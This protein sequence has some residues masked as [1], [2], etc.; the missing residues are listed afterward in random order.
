MG[1]CECLHSWICVTCVPGALSGQG[2]R[3]I[4]GC[5]SPML[6]IGFELGSQ[7]KQYSLLTTEHL[8]NH[9]S[10]GV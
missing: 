5:E 3:A 6:V 8:S 1:I 4:R 10:S 7:E 2:V 9:Q